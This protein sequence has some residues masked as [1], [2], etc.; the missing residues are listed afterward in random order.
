M[1]NASSDEAVRPAGF[2]RILR[3]D[4]AAARAHDPAA[5]GDL[6]NAVVYSGLHAIWLH[7]LSHRMWQSGG[8][9]RVAVQPWHDLDTGSRRAVDEQAQRLAAF[10]GVRL[11]GVLLG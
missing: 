6:E 7:R 10:R 5:R 3:E 2:L 1:T 4:L 11:A 8:A 9:L